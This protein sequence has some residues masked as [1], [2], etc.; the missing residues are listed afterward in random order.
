VAKYNSET[1]ERIYQLVC[2]GE[3]T[4]KQICKIV[5]IAEDTFYTWKK[6][7]PEFS[8]LLKKAEEEK[9]K[10]LKA[11]AIGG[12][13][14]LLN[15]AKFDEVTKELKKV[16]GENKLIETKRVTKVIQPNP[17]SVIFALKN[18]DKENFEDVQ[19][20]VI[21]DNV[22]GDLP[23]SEKK[24]IIK[25]IEE[26]RANSQTDDKDTATQGAT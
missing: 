24:K 9:Y 16:D 11:L 15:G 4:Q 18:L 13:R 5:G 23:L 7:K 19:K 21:E 6:D 10:S 25:A 22:L 26:A 17:T 14:K 8:E 12:F 3:Y 1:T 20:K 2:E